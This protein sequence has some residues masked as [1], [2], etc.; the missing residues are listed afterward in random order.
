[1]PSMPFSP[2]A[3]LGIRP[4]SDVRFQLLPFQCA[5]VVPPN[6]QMFEGDRALAPLSL[7]ADAD[8]AQ[9]MPLKCQVPPGPKTQTSVWLM[10]VPELSSPLNFCITDQLWPLKRSASPV[11]PSSPTCMKAQTLLEDVEPADTTWSYAAPGK[12]R[13][14][15]RDPLSWYALGRPPSKLLP[16]AHALVALAAVIAVKESLPPVNATRQDFAAVACTAAPAGI[17]GSNGPPMTAVV[18]RIV[19][20]RKSRMRSPVG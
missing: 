4:A 8:L 13:C 7:P 1:M 19:A 9:V 5:T 16:K 17:A 3:F 2:S 12:L 14:F 20:Q 11:C 15:H 6:A 18:T 10:T